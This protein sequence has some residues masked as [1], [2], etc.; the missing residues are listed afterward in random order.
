MI[1]KKWRVIHGTGCFLVDYGGW[2]TMRLG[3][4]IRKFLYC[5]EDI[6]IRF[7]YS[8][9][10]TPVVCLSSYEGEKIVNKYKDKRVIKIYSDRYNGKYSEII[11]ICI[12]LED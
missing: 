8:L 2:E 7:I 6:K 5:F 3:K 4:F 12:D 11:C 1:I 10:E 9:D